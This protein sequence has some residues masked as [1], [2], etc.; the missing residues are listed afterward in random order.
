MKLY[1]MLIF[2]I[3]SAQLQ[4]AALPEK[5][6]K[7]TKIKKEKEEMLVAAYSQYQ[8]AML[9]KDPEKI[10]NAFASMD[11]ALRQGASPDGFLENE[12]GNY[13][14]LIWAIL[15]DD[16][17]VVR[18]LIEYNVD[19]NDQYEALGL[20]TPLMG[21]IR[22]NP[23]KKNYKEII[24]TLIK[25]LA[26]RKENLNLQD[27]WGRT[28]FWH[29]AE[30]KQPDVMKWL[31]EAGAEPSYKPYDFYLEKHPD[32]ITPDM[33]DLIAQYIKEQK[34]AEGDPEALGLYD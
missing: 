25:Y 34:M 26:K 21:A 10:L 5:S 17:A 29:A 3:V 14:L 8:L 30:N 15:Q 2:F 9:H 4:A 28:A 18:L 22:M 20:E 32:T 11:S 1:H 33:R 31:F 7:E 19:A 6:S 23:S 16:L 12:F 27:E 13:P 24:K